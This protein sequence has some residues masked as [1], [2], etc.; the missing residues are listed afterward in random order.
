MKGY[1]YMGGRHNLTLPG[2]YLTDDHVALK[3][4]PNPIPRLSSQHSE[5]G[6]GSGRPNTAEWS[7]LSHLC[8][9]KSLSSSEGLCVQLNGMIVLDI[10]SASLAVY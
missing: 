1:Y 2:S 5:R 8:G 3:Q 4:T 7:G 6:I 9:S 10:P